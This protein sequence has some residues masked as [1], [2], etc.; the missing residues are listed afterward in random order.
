LD[1]RVDELPNV[2]I[3]NLSVC[4]AGRIPAHHHDGFVEAR[5]LA[6]VSVN[7][8]SRSD[9]YHSALFL[10]SNFGGFELRPEETPRPELG[11]LLVKIGAVALNPVDWKTQKLGVFVEDYPVVL[12]W[13]VGESV[14]R[15]VKGDN[16]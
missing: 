15:F 5:G 9:G 11:Q 6:Q 1:F 16:V 10:K 2:I 4:Q 14:S 7:N 3:I 8:Y 13:D 12:G